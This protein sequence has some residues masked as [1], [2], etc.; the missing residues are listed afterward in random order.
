MLG[1]KLVTNYINLKSRNNYSEESKQYFPRLKSIFHLSCYLMVRNESKSKSDRDVISITK[2]INIK[3]VRKYAYEQFNKHMN[4]V[5][6]RQQIINKIIEDRRRAARVILFNLK[7]YK[8]IKKKNKNIMIRKILKIRIAAAIFIQKKYR[9]YQIRKSVKKL[10]CKTNYLFIYKFDNTD[11]EKIKPITLK[12]KLTKSDQS[13]TFNYCKYTDTYYISFP[14]TK[15]LPRRIRVNFS[16]NDK[17][18]IDPRYDVDCVKGIFYNII[19]C[20]KI[21]NMQTQRR[22][23]EYEKMFEI[24]NSV[25]SENSVSDKS[26]V[27]DIDRTFS[28]KI[29]HK[30]KRQTSPKLVVS[31]KQQV[32]SI[33]KKCSTKTVKRVQ[34][35]LENIYNN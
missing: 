18:I 17:P 33:L 4:E 21:K 19:D 5:E 35:S 34:F 9:M 6:L 8:N 22:S 28:R 1:Q 2:T 25:N 14:K 16:V 31:Q 3:T 7:K 10:L 13:Y 30:V 23:N 29:S 20:S 12:L 24:N 27:S 15:I 11:Y 26:E 32:K